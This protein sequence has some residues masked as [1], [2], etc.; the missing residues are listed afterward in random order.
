MV[1][2]INEKN[3]E[4]INVFRIK[5][6]SYRPGVF[7]DGTYTVIVGEGEYSKEFKGIRPSAKSDKVIKVNF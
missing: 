3:N 6:T 5:G 2:V 1:K 7:I 4:V